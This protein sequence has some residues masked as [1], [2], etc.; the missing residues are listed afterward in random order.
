MYAKMHTINNQK[1]LACCE[2]ELINKKIE[3]EDLECEIKESFY[4]GKEINEEELKEML[5]EANIINLVGEK[6]IQIAIKE[7]FINTKDII[8]MDNV[9]HVQILKL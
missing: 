5:K 3:N 6:P 8:K 1:I 4:K 2:E 7:G 9:P